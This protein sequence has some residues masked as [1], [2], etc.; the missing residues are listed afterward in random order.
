MKMIDDRGEFRAALG[1]FERGEL[2]AE[3]TALLIE[4]ALLNFPQEV[5]DRAAD[6]SRAKNGRT[7]RLRGLV[8]FTNICRNDCYYCGIRASNGEC[9]R[10]RLTEDEIMECCDTGYR[11]GFRTFVLQGGEDP[12]FTD[13]KLTG[14]I[15][16]IRKKY[17]ESA[18]TLSIGERSR[19]SFQRL[20][21]AGA[22]RFLL[23]HES[24]SPGHYEKLHPENLSWENRKKCLFYLKEIGF[25]TGAGFMVGSPYQTYADLAADLAFLRELQPEM[26]GIGAFI[27]H[28]HTP[29]RD[30]PAGALPLTLVMV[31]LTRILLPAA[32]IPAT[33]ALA[34]ISQDGRIQ[35]LDAGANVVMPN[36][37]PKKYR[38]LYTLYNGKPATGEEAAESLDKLKTQLERAGYRLDIAENGEN[39]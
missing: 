23:R 17:P 29:F 6:I 18:V 33:T 4:A 1:R 9:V 32:N 15:S 8:E 27:P 3:E 25:E 28:E 10:Y 16:A 7:V 24:A 19:E 36:L 30:F 11:L 13:E 31:A 5:S 39:I 38:S 20:Y 35:A 21:D 2:S 37:S 26:V 22:E 34:A 12:Y 14:I